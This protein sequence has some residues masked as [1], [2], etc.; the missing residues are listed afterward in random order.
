MWQTQNMDN[1]RNQKSNL[2]I[3]DAYLIGDVLFV[4]PTFWQLRRQP[5]Y[6][7]QCDND[8]EINATKILLN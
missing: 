1:S 5:K 4:Q 2:I 7:K 6:R 8:T 3:Q